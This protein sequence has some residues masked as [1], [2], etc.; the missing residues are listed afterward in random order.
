MPIVA[1]TMATTSEIVERIGGAELLAKRFAV[2]L[3]AIEM[4]GRRGGIPPKWHFDLLRLA[5]ERGV[6]LSLEELSTQSQ[7]AA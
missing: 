4:W 2:S 6:A 7:R 1:S 5:E 3:K